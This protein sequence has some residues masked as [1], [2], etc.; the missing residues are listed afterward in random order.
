MN[1]DNPETQPEVQ[2]CMYEFSRVY[3]D[4]RCT[5]ISHS[6]TNMSNCAQINVCVLCV[7]CVLCVVDSFSAIRGP[8]WRYILSNI[9]QAWPCVQPTVWQTFFMA[10]TG[11]PRSI[12]SI[13]AIR[14]CCTSKLGHRVSQSDDSVM[15]PEVVTE[16]L[17]KPLWKDQHWSQKTYEY[18]ML[19]WCENMGLVCLMTPWSLWLVTSTVLIQWQLPVGLWLTIYVT[20]S[21]QSY[22]GKGWNLKSNHENAAW[23]WQCPKAVMRTMILCL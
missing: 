22:L 16:F 7:L 12:S 23:P 19:L 2:H 21:V 11:S 13:T 17:V 3:F 1:E 14:L 4:N 18:N 5:F 20:M 9:S 8:C 10:G 6:N 15:R